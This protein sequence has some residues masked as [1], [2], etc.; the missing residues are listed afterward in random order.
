[1]VV[2]QLS[3]FSENF[4]KLYQGQMGVQKERYAINAVAS[5]VH[6]VEQQWAKR[7]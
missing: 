4:M 6:K 7:N 5:L 2:E 1:M 3:Y